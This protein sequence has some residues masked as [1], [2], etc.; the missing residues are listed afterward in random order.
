MLTLFAVFTV[1]AAG[2]CDSGSKNKNQALI[3]PDE[4]EQPLEAFGIVKPVHVI[5]IAV[6]IPALIEEICVKKGQRV[7]KGD[8]LAVINMDGYLKQLEIKENEIESLK[9]E[10]DA[11]Q[12]ELSGKTDI[13]ESKSHPQIK[14]LLN[15]LRYAKFSSPKDAEDIKYS[16][17]ILEFTMSE[18]LRTLREGLKRAQD[19]LFVLE[20]EFNHMKSL[21]QN[22]IISEGKIICDIE[23]GSVSDIF[24]SPGVYA[25][26][27]TSLLKITDSDSLVVEA[28]VDEQFITRVKLGADAFIIP[29]ADREHTYWGKV[30]FIA[31]EAVQSYGE[32][33][34]PV[35]IT[36]DEPDGFLLP[37]F[38]V[39]IRIEQK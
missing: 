21:I 3:P 12:Q 32:T 2:G 24:V 17:D 27:G 9:E 26:A 14:K 33:S 31:S 29:D 20:S 4:S 22:K 7:K 8:V 37:G 25:G 15:D 35:Q 18:E 34:V 38:N 10:Q 23:N 30:T 13:L 1:I 5:D 36:V 39:E 6:E 11:A 19:M 28:N 16:I